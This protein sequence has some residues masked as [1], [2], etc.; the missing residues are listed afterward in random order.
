M[1]GVP[2]AKRAAAATD[3]AAGNGHGSDGAADGGAA[4]KK[5]RVAQGEAQELPAAAN[6]ADV[7]DP[8]LLLP[9]SRTELADQFNTSQPYPH[10]VIPRLC[11]PELLASVRDEIVSNIQATYKET[12]LFKVFQ[13]GACGQAADGLCGGGH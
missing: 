7:L 8:Q 2:E 4:A 10:L 13:T 1:A 12:D 3:A 9:P 11:K 6:A 5:Q